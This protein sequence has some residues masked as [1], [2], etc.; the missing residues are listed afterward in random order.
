MDC[1]FLRI[2]YIVEETIPQPS[3]QLLDPMRK[4][5]NVCQHC[6]ARVVRRSPVRKAT[7]GE[8]A[9][10]EEEDAASPFLC[11]QGSLSSTLTH[12]LN[13]KSFT[14]IAL[15]EDWTGATQRVCCI[16][17]I[18][19]KLTVVDRESAPRHN[20][21]TGKNDAWWL[22]SPHQMTSHKW[23]WWLEGQS[24]LADFP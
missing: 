22:K 5:G 7:R 1:I 13:L 14:V 21:T 19:R 10:G 23:I 9:G 15:V 17:S 3:A 18:P 2:C 11:P 24:W 4:E 16:Y 6:P 20:P 8:R 12:H